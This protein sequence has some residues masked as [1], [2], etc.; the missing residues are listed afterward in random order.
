MMNNIEKEIKVISDNRGKLISIESGSD[1]PFDIKRVY[2]LYDNNCSTTR[3][4]HAHKTLKQLLLCTS[5]SCRV[6][7]DDGHERISYDLNEISKGL[8]IDG[9]IWREISNF[10]K[11][12]VLTVIAS[13]VFDEKD[14]IRDYNE[15]K[16]YINIK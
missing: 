13:E 5:G 15:F 10:S 8:F 4:F 1:I 2:F 3:G 16:K 14:Y 11:E 7:L 12:C 9:I 6:M